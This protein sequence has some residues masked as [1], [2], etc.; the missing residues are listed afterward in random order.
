MSENV[1]V[2]LV[3]GDNQVGVVAVAA[4]HLRRRHDGAGGRLD[5]VGDVEQP[6]DEQPVAGDALIAQGI[7]IGGRVT[8]G[9]GRRLQ[10]EAALGADGDDD[11]VL[12]RLAP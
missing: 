8:G 7:A 4:H 9:R 3:G 6:G 1:A 5:V 11:G 12:H 10:H 2:A